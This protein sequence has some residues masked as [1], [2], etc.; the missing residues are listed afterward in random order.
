[1]EYSCVSLEIFT[2]NGIVTENH[3]NNLWET[4]ERIFVSIVSIFFLNWHWRG[5]AERKINNSSEVSYQMFT[6]TYGRVKAISKSEENYKSCSLTTIWYTG[7]ALLVCNLSKW[8]GKAVSE[9]VIARSV[10]ASGAWLTSAKIAEI[11]SAASY[12]VKINNWIEF[13]Y[14]S[15]FSASI[16]RKEQNKKLPPVGIEPTTS[17]SSF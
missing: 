7:A 1:M 11:T 17:R 5:K 4:E 16:D 13:F 10:C 12:I 15:L 14:N 8:A 6:E 2:D 9:N 3:G